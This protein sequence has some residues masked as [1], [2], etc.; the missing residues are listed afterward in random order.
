MDNANIVKELKTAFQMLA[1]LNVNGD[2][3][4]VMAAVRAKLRKTIEALEKD[5]GEN[6]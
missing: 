3:V 2:A 1:T 5:G 4:D 6:G